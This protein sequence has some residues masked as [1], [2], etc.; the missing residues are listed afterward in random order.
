VSQRPIALAIMAK[1]PLLGAPKSRLQPAL[2]AEQT[3]RLAAA[4]LED[5]CATVARADCADLWICFTPAE[6]HAELAALLGQ[7]IVLL[8]QRGSSLSERVIHAFHDLFARGY[9]Q[10]MLMN[11]DTPDLPAEYL[12]SA[13][14]RLAKADNRLVL[15]PTED[16]GY[17]LV[18]LHH[19]AAAALD[20]LFADIHWSTPA[21][22]RETVERAAALALALE[23]LPFWYDIDT[24]DD[25]GRLWSRLADSKG[26]AA[27]RTYASLASI[28]G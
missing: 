10:V 7:D 6:A 17:Y 16:G 25:L 4:F 22:L 27:P 2:S 15:G 20:A 12:R 28:F 18:G 8:P 5:T 26:A 1:A 23:L 13:A 19:T 24:P 21:V 11:A 14:H 9:A 3:A